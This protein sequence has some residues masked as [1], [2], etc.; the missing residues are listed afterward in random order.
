MESGFSRELFAEWAGQPRNSVILTA[1]AQKGTLAYDLIHCGGNDRVIPLDMYKRVKLTGAE[2]EEYR[3]QQRDEKAKAKQA[4]SGNDGVLILEDD[5]SSDE[6]MDT[7]VTSNKKGGKGGKDTKVVKH[8]II[9]KSST[10]TA[11]DA[12]LGLM[13][14]AQKQS[15]FKSTKSKYPMFPFHEVKIKWDDYGEI[16]KP[17][18][19]IDPTSDPKMEFN[20]GGEN[21]NGLLMQV[22]TMNSKDGSVEPMEIPTK[23]VITPIRL[24]IKAQIQYI[25]FEGRSDGESI[26]KCLMQMKPRR[27]IIVRGSTDNGKALA[28]FCI[29]LLARVAN[30]DRGT[31]KASP[32]AIQRVFMPKNGETIDATTESYIY[33]VRLPDSLMSGLIFQNGKDNTQL[34]WVD[35]RIRKRKQAE[36]NLDI[37]EAGKETPLENNGKE[38][39]LDLNLDNAKISSEDLEHDNTPIPTLEP[40]E[41]EELKGHQTSFINELKLSDFKIVL[42]KHNVPSEF[43]GGV[44]FCGSNNMV[45]LRRHDSGH[46]TVEGCVCEDYYLVRSLLYERYAIV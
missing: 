19:W 41:E 14:G 17:E 7:V 36:L 27:V 20:R 40:I 38:L 2:L 1:R 9:M 30:D 35:G 4:T 33:Q 42:S 8:D 34:A 29:P 6:E 23:C 18:D 21:A 28:E 5:E 3:R 12:A 15:F 46:V 43:Q 37:T 32:K 39:R 16:I 11:Q 10:S 25:D 24:Q 45:A 13:L 22:E 44:L 26:H 31:D